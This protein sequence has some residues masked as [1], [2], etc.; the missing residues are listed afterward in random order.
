LAATEAGDME[1]LDPVI[2]DEIARLNDKGF[3]EGPQWINTDRK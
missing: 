2:L 1:R 3:V